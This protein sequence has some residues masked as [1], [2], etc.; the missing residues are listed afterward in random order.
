MLAA[1]RK[2]GETS[3]NE[4]SSRSHQILRLV[5]AYILFSLLISNKYPNCFFIKLVYE[6]NFVTFVLMNTKTI[7]S[8]TREYVRG[9]S[10]RSLAATVVW[11]FLSSLDEY[12]ISKNLVQ[13]VPKNEI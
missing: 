1:Q 6:Y 2:I 3:M 4:T 7:K 9:R 11:K 8:S 5:Y 13:L 10:A 12:K